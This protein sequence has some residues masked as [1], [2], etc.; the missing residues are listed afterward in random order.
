[1]DISIRNE[2][3]KDY[4]KVE[5]LTREA[6]WNLHVKG[7]D[8]HYLVY[9]MRSHPDFIANLD[10]VAILEGK[11]V[12][13]IMYTKSCIVDESNNKMDTITFGPISVLPEY[14]KRGIGSALIQHSI[15][16]ARKYD[17]KAIIIHGH[18]HNY[19]KHCF[20]SSKDYKIS[21]SEGKY[22]Y[23]LLA[24]ELKKGI[25][26]GHIWK[27]CPSDV[28]NIN[29]DDVEEYDKQFT[30]KK[31]EYRYSQEEFSIASRTYID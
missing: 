20:K 24:L 23:S 30:H 12:G 15:K 28:F 11:I 10:F 21:D 3:E 14:Q 1:M 27:Y 29:H 25:F 7:C 9:K 4:R 16:V 18:P 5:E 2:Q 13:N 26:Q 19:C 8:E 17:F 6:F 31:K 22:P